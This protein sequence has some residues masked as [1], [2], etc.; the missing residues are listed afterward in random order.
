MPELHLDPDF[1]PGIAQSIESHYL[2]L[3]SWLESHLPR[4]GSLLACTTLSLY[5]R[6]LADRAR[7]LAIEWPFILRVGLFVAVVGFGFSLIIATVAPLITAGLAMAGTP[8]LVPA[9]FACFLIV[10]ILAER[11]GR[12]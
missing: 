6:L 10:G 8:Y 5:G 3:S 7:Q 12:I 11:S 9:T 1:L 2:Q 4:I